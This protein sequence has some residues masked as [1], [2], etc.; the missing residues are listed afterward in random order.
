[1]TS[2]ERKQIDKLEKSLNAVKAADDYQAIRKGI[3]IL[4]RGTMHLAEMMMD[5]AV[6]T[7]L[8]GK[9]IDQADMGEAPNVGRPVAKAEFE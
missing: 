3:E 8:K 9:T 5:N 6:S 7:A 1:M 4:N 2:D